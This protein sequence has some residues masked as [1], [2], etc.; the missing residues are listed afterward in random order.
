MNILSQI[1]LWIE[2]SGTSKF[3]GPHWLFKA[4]FFPGF[5]KRLLFCFKRHGSHYFQDLLKI[6]SRAFQ[7]EEKK[8]IIYNSDYH[9]CYTHTKKKWVF[10]QNVIWGIKFR[11]L[12]FLLCLDCAILNSRW[13]IFWCQEI[14]LLNSIAVQLH[15]SI[16]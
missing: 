15:F 1:S 7:S 10:F 14:S 3:W 5:W 11:I 16:Y 13:Y 4:P 8:I 6:F 12:F 9:Y 2:F